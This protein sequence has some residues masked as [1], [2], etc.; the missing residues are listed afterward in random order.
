M[1]Q[2][3][4]RLSLAVMTAA[5]ASALQA[6]TPSMAKAQKSDAEWLEDCRDRDSGGSRRDG[7][8]SRERERHC[9][10]RDTGLRAPG[11]PIS[12]DPGRNGGI[13]V[14]GWDRDSI[15]ITMRIRTSAESEGAAADLAKEIKISTTNG[16]IRV[17]A[18]RSREDEQVSV[19]LDVMVPRKSALSLEAYNGPIGV[20]HV[21]GRIEFHSV[22]GPV[23]LVGVGGDVR[24][25]TS[26]G[27]L[28]VEL[29]GKRWDG[30]G[31]DVSTSNG[32]VTLEV[33]DDYNAELETG[34]SNG[35]MRIDFPVTVQGRF[36]RRLNTKLG[37]GGPVV[38]VVTTN[39][40]VIIRRP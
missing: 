1:K 17:D 25:R 26:N 36:G 6:A 15:A 14:E 35:P 22:N 40:P 39:G 12:I 27:P 8:W 21:S 30:A 9:E 4:V 13:R 18:P 10:I 23:K 37:T 11:G 20:E 24:G 3:L 28:H 31:L 16:D 33:P 32:P 29:E 38:R 34:T 5:S 2:I 19:E 7:W